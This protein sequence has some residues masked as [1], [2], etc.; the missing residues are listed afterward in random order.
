MP[1]RRGRQAA[2][3]WMPR[4]VIACANTVAEDM[5][6]RTQDQAGRG[7]PQGG[8]GVPAHQ[9]PARLPDLRPGGRVPAAGI[10]RR[11][12]QRRL[13]LPRAEGQEAEERGHRP[14]HHARRRA[15]H[16]VLPLHPLHERDRR[17]PCS[18]SSS[19]AASPRWPSIRTARSTTTTRSTPW[20]SARSARSPR[21]TSA[22]RCA[23][24]SSRK[25]RPSTSTAAPA[26]TPRSGPRENVIYRITPRENN[27]VNSCWMP[28]APAQ[29]PL[30]QQRSAA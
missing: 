11:L 8:D 25:P 15:L 16:H 3:N 5:G 14:A 7:M 18:A 23:S 21:T 10:L 2:I 28:D 6:I 26:A 29:L 1:R 27:D 24:G 20:T 30:R 17:R 9:P 22:S 12:R 13:A 4:P 19:A